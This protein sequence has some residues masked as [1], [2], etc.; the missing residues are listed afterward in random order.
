MIV[1]IVSCKKD[2]SIEECLE[3]LNISGNIS[4]RT[5]KLPIEGIRI[6]F[7]YG[8]G[9]KTTLISETF[10]DKYG[11]FVINK[12]LNIMIIQLTMVIGLVCQQLMNFIQLTR[13]E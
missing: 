4:D 7:R 5:T 11:N 1:F 8:Y 2:A 3:T 12:E 10:T 6:T 13:I 9:I